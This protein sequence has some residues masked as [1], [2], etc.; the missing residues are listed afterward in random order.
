MINNISFSTH[1]MICPDSQGS[2]TLAYT[3]WGE[4][5]NSKVLICLHGLTRN[6]RDFDTLASVLSTDYRVLCIDIAGRGQSDWLS[7]PE[8]YTYETYVTDMLVLLEH[9][10]LTKIDLVGTSMGGLIGM[11][12]AARPASPISKLVINDIGALVPKTGL[13]RIAKY[14]NQPRPQFATLQEVE[15]YCRIV[16]M[17]FGNLTNVQWQHLAK[18]SVKAVTGGGY[19]LRYDPAIAIPF[20]GELEDIDLWS[21]WEQVRCPVLVLHGEKSDLLSPQIIQKMQAKHPLTQTVTFPEVGH[22]PPLMS[23]EQ[24]A[25]VKSWLL[26]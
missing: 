13:Q 17:L 26:G 2:H 24:I 10:H 22:A 14:L 19:R 25:V 8:N 12:L 18:H 7:Q 5:D 11:F 3:E 16:H 23:E 6:G 4:P 1:S 21:I 20:K 9:L 15:K